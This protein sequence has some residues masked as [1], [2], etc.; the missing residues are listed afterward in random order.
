MK[1]K[2][3]NNSQHQLPCYESEGAACVDLR[4]SFTNLDEEFKGEKFEKLNGIIYLLPGGR[5]LIS[6]DLFVA[7]PKGYEIQIRPRSGL[8]I[9]NGISCVNTPGC[10]DSDYRGNIGIILINHGSKTFEIK[11][12]DKIAQAKLSKVEKIEWDEVRSKD[13]LS[14]TTRGANGFGSTGK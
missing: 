2:V 8:A 1:V 13:D 3:F 6:T 11:N 4:A 12:G 5:I 14:K 7:I 9:K 10:I